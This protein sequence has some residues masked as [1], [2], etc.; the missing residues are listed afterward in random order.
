M[1]KKVYHESGIYYLKHNQRRKKYTLHK[2][3]LGVLSGC[4]IGYKCD[5]DI[6]NQDQLLLWIKVKLDV[7]GREKMIRKSKR[8]IIKNWD[9]Y[10]SKSIKRDKKINK[11]I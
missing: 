2:N 3:I 8:D 7:I 4:S 10:T 1:T 6:N 5:S 11:I 9:G